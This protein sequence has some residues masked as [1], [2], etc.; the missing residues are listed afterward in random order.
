MPA[1][2]PV[3]AEYDVLLAKWFRWGGIAT[4][5][6]LVTFVLMVFKPAF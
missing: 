5:L 1:G 2:G 4:L 3:P 6:P